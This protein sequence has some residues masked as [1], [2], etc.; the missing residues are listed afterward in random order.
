MSLFVAPPPPG[1]GESEVEDEE[2]IKDEIE[3]EEEE[4]DIDEGP[5]GEDPKRS[6][7][8]WNKNWQICKWIALNCNQDFTTEN[9]H[10]AVLDACKEFNINKHPPPRSCKKKF[11]DWRK[12]AWKLNQYDL[13][14]TKVN[15]GGG[16]VTEKQS[17]PMGKSVDK[18]NQDFKKLVEELPCSKHFTQSEI[19][20]L[21]LFGR[22]F[23][24]PVNSKEAKAVAALDA[25]AAR[26]K[27]QLKRTKYQEVIST[28]TASN[29]ARYT[30][31]P[32]Y[33]TDSSDIQ[34]SDEPRQSAKKTPK[35]VENYDLSAQTFMAQNE[36]N[37]IAMKGTVSDLI[38]AAA[39]AFNGKTDSEEKRFQQQLQV[40]EKRFQQQL[41][42]DEKRIETELKMKSEI[43]LKRFEL[44]EKRLLNEIEERRLQREFEERRLQREERIFA[45]LMK[46]R[47]PFTT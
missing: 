16:T 40:D 43:E 18:A 24:A 34:Q 39:T 13:K 36:A 10:L 8:N 28:A 38:H 4:D 20:Q 6:N 26:E 15:N 9:L 41:Q 21:I 23:K 1:F 19:N 29:P 37:N 14:R 7:F 30:P 2:E 44:E 12:F 32:A 45:L 46:N 27:E 33:L 25:A 42:V 31:S 17:K 35:T 3:E 47:E 5:G 22:D 11:L